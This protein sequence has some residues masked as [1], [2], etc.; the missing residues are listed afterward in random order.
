M[1]ECESPQLGVTYGQADGSKSSCCA[2]RTGAR[3]WKSVRQD[4]RRDLD[5]SATAHGVG[6][7]KRLQRQREAE[8]SL[9]IV[10]VLHIPV[11]GTCIGGVL[12]KYQAANDGLRPEGSTGR[13]E[14]WWAET[15]RGSGE[16]KA[17]SMS[18][19]AMVA[20]MQSMAARVWLVG[21]AP[22]FALLHSRPGFV[23]W[24]T[25]NVDTPEYSILE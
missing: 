12:D 5:A 25:G 22:R 4:G 17:W 24:N 1:N 19:R 14:W 20:R 6:L 21:R 16:R 3:A 9:D 8:G 7:K 2:G 11:K 10:V 15:G 13:G 23:F 18:S